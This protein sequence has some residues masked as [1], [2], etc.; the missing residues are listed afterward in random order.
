MSD[1]PVITQGAF[2]S[3]NLAFW[4]PTRGEYRAYWRGFRD[5]F[6]DI[7]T[8]TS[9]GFVHWTEPV[10]LQYP[11]A[12]RQELYTN[13]ILPYYRAPHIL[14]G[15][16]TRYIERGWSDS[17]RALPELEARRSRSAISDRYGMAL[18]DGLFMSSRD[19][20]TFHRWSEAFIRPGQRGTDNWAYGDNYQCWGLVE[21][22]AVIPDASDEISVYATEGYNLGEANKL[23]RFTLRRDGFVS[24]HAPFAG[25]GFTTKLVTFRGDRLILN[26]STSAAGTIRVEI[27]DADGKPIP[28]FALA[29][30]SEVFGDTLER[31]VTWK[32]GAD[33]S[34]LAGQPVRLHFTL[35][36][37]DLFSFRFVTTGL[38]DPGTGA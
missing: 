35:S 20:Q 30:C 34:K 17:M 25:G 26:F 15:F 21:T 22:K 1:K 2:D 32:Q 18:T 31:T 33:V 8:A 29:D 19:G 27:Q 5:G 38:S 28:G 13:Q 12:P 10:W 3:Q 37:A 9:K 7:L 36:D 6:R 23:R 14:L 4:D 11:G 24:M 16:P